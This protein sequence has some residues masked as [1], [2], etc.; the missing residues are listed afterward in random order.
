MHLRILLDVYWSRNEALLLAL[1][2]DGLEALRRSAVWGCCRM[3]CDDEPSVL[4]SVAIDGN[5][6]VG[7]PADRAAAA[8]GDMLCQES[9]VSCA[10]TASNLS[11]CPEAYSQFHERRP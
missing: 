2:A 10:C 1:S 6:V 8:Y 3:S 11:C 9:N 4:R 5:D 7:R